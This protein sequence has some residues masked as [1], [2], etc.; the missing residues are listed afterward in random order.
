MPGLEV[1][2]DAVQTN[3][4]IAVTRSDAWEAET[5][6]AE[7]GVLAFALDAERLRFVFHADVGEEAV[8]AAAEACRGL[9]G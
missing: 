8:G 1:D 3:M 7:A 5:A 2:L 9:F 6:L 4:V